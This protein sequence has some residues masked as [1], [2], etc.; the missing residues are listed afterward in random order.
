MGGSLRSAA[1]GSQGVRLD[2]HWCLCGNWLKRPGLRQFR[3]FF[4]LDV[5]SVTPRVPLADRAEM[6]VGHDSL[7]PGIKGIVVGDAQA[8]VGKVV[9]P[10]LQC[11]GAGCAT[12]APCG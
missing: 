9:G 6:R 1:S 10:V 3:A 5:L 4:D 12:L 7:V 11:P 8:V 2:L